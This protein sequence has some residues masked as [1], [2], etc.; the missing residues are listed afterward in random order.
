MHVLD[1]SVVPLKFAKDHLFV[2][3]VRKLGLDHFKVI[4]DFGQFVRIC[5]LTASLFE[6]L[7]CFISQLVYLV[8]KHV[9]HGLQI[10]VVQLVAVDHV[11][12]AML[13]NG[14]AEADS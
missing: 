5:L 2:L 9:D 6:Q 7:G 12:I 4:D 13:A 10:R 8:V 3:S 11:V 1:L 14:T